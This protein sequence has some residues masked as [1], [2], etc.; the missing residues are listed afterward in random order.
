MYIICYLKYMLFLKIRKY[1]D[2]KVVRYQEDI[3]YAGNNFSKWRL[4]PEISRSPPFFKWHVV[5][6]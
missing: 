5:L 1:C 3:T 2:T 4:L 6:F